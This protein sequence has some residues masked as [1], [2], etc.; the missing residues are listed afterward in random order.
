MSNQPVSLQV[1]ILMYHSISYTGT[2]DFLPFIVRPHEFARQME[3]LHEHRFTPIT[4]TEYVRA[5]CA[6]GKG[7]PER[8]VV[9][10]FD[11]GYGDFYDHALPVLK[12]YGYSAT[13]YIPTNCIGATSDCLSSSRIVGRSM[14]TWDMIRAIHHAGI[15]IGAHSH[16]HPQLDLLPKEALRDEIALPKE[17]LEKQ[18]GSPVNS[19]AYPHG[20]HSQVVIDEVRNVGYSSAC[21]VKYAMSHLEDDPYALARLLVPI[22][23]SIADFRRLLRGESVPLA[24]KGERMRTK[25]WRCIRRFKRRQQGQV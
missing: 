13:L 3:H 8:P 18:L 14:L 20:Y 2:H 23:I 15:E 17:I 5:L 19:F 9:I 1:P 4:V 22:N 25:V 24:R 21:A 11:D 10:T 6:R 7:L 12:E 16:T